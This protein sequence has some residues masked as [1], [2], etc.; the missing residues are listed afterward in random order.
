MNKRSWIVGLML[1]VLAATPVAMA[2][3]EKTAKDQAAAEE[4]QKADEQADQDQA[5]DL[6]K[7]MAEL[8]LDHNVVPARMLNLPWAGKTRT[9]REVMEKLDQWSQKDEIGAVM[10]NITYFYLPLADV[11][12]LRQGIA[13]LKDEG[14]KVFVYLHVSSPEGYL[15]ACAA[16][17]IC[18]APVGAVILPGFG[19]SFPFMQ[20]HFQMRGLEYDVLTAGKYKYPGFVNQR[21]PNKYF[22][23]EFGAL[24]DSW[25]EDYVNMV[26]QGRELKPD[27]VRKM[28][29]QA[30]LKA[31]QALQRGLADHVASLSDYRDRLLRREGMKPYEGDEVDWSQINSVQDVLNMMSREWQKEKERRE[32]VGPK[33]AVLHA[34]GPFIDV[35]LGPAYATMIICRDD[36]LKTIEEIRRNKS[37]KGVVLRIDSPGGSGYASSAIYH[38]LME[39]DQ[40]KPLVVSMGR[41]AASAGYHIA[42]PARMI[43][44]QPTTITGSIGVLGIVRSA[45]S[46][47]NRADYN[48]AFMQ[49]GARALLARGYRPL[50]KEDRAFIQKLIDNSYD[51]FIDDVARGRK[52][53]REQV[54]E[55]AGG[56]VYSGRDAL[57]VG[58]IDRLGGLEDAVEAVR[59]MAGIPAE[60]KLRLVHYPRM[61]S[62]G[63]FV[64]GFGGTGTP[65]SDMSADTEDNGLIN[66][67]GLAEATA[68]PL[69]WE[70]QLEL[71]SQTVKPLYWMPAPDLR[72]VWSSGAASPGGAAYWNEPAPGQVKELILS[73]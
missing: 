26:C 42:C 29:D 9:L 21:E 33:I 50:P 62:L 47:L 44:A 60:A 52:M 2:D 20:G 11:E 36:M 28:V 5:E 3:E 32:A 53:A 54:R 55:L 71:L 48:L 65:L 17:E 34:R 15:L 41:V 22:K 23:D 1:W 49:R 68:G 58:L 56:R 12:E 61:A 13:K 7:K 30:V 72:Y 27:K 59:E 45:W 40:D 25:F 10:L 73:P 6:V 4:V 37:I 38:K 67:L 46:A 14:K 69:S 24:L 51:D 18:L 43:F 19:Y 57:K 66:M 63:E 31:D 35:S 39:L 8:T 64:A 70:K 16:D